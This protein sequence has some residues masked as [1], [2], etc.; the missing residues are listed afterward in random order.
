MHKTIVEC[1]I[2][3]LLIEKLRFNQ[4]NYKKCK[5]GAKDIYEK[6]CKIRHT[7]GGFPQTKSTILQ[8]AETGIL[9]FKILTLMYVIKDNEKV[10]VEKDLG[11]VEKTFRMMIV[12]NLMATKM[13]IALCKELIAKDYG[14]EFYV[15]AKELCEEVFIKFAMECQ[16][17]FSVK[18]LSAGDIYKEAESRPFEHFWEMIPCYNLVDD[19]L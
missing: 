6:F 16:G 10:K 5:E 8:F 2:G 17:V 1:N 9:F 3:Y 4:L 18:T 14:T 13:I 15:F 7:L 12:D 11:F 19:I